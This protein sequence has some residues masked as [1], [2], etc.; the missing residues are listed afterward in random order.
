MVVDNKLNP[1]AQPGKSLLP[2][3]KS[4]VVLLPLLKYAPRP[5]IHSVL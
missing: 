1:T 3:K 2:R 4:S 5:A